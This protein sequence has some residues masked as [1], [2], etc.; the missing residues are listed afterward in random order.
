MAAM[1]GGA[2]MGVGAAM[3]AAGT[4]DPE[5]RK[6]FLVLCAVGF[7]AAFVMGLLVWRLVSGLWTHLLWLP[8]WVGILWLFHHRKKHGSR[9]RR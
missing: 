6:H 5:K 3:L 9:W 4:K 2:M 7:Y 1:V 8:S